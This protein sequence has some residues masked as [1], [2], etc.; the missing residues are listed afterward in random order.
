MIEMAVCPLCRV[1]LMPPV[2][3]ALWR[4]PACL[5]EIQDVALTSV[6]G[7]TRRWS[8]SQVPPLVI[9]R[10]ILSLPEKDQALLEEF[11]QEAEVLRQRV[12]RGQ[13]SKNAAQFQIDLMRAEVETLLGEAFDAGYLK[14]G[15]P[16]T[17]AGRRPPTTA[18]TGPGL[19][20]RPTRRILLKDEE[21]HAETNDA[22]GRPPP[23]SDP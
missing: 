5:F 13:L 2:M 12:A 15:P 9:A 21:D 10:A 1:E 4:C 18:V 23:R 11:K 3:D 7:T 6:A 17:P 22:V 16:P 19:A 14:I 20:P 8:Q